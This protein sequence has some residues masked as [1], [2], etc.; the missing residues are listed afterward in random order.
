MVFDTNM[1]TKDGKKMMYLI[2]IGVKK[3]CENYDAIWAELLRRMNAVSI[4][5]V[6][7]DWALYDDNNE[8][9]DFSDCLFYAQT[10]ET[11]MGFVNG[12]LKE[13][14]IRSNLEFC[15]FYNGDAYKND[16]KKFDAEDT[17]K[18]KKEYFA[19]FHP[20]EVW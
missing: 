5:I 13:H 19:E 2:S 12:I 4:P 14:E 18:E 17:I 1:V 6:R 7:V 9:N 10:F 15:N 8:P 3:D 11:G 20:D 16:M